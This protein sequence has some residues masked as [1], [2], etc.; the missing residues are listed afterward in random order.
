MSARWV[1]LLS[2]RKSLMLISLRICS[3]VSV[4][5]VIAIELV[6][7]STR[8]SCPFDSILS[9]TL[10]EKSHELLVHIAESAES[11]RRGPPFVGAQM[12]HGC[13]ISNV[14]V[15]YAVALQRRPCPPMLELLNFR[16]WIS[17]RSAGASS[18]LRR[19]FK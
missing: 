5:S 9:S 10:P 14:F 12:N 4:K 7:F 19:R 1:L 3:G 18:R 13:L 8:T 16:F 2:P 11:Q 17:W 6:L 15:L